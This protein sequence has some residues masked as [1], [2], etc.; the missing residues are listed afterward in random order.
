[1]PSSNTLL[2]LHSLAYGGEVGY[3]WE[4]HAYNMRQPVHD[5]VNSRRQ[6][7]AAPDESEIIEKS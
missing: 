4:I 3:G 6:I 7:M 1:M 5:P 2:N